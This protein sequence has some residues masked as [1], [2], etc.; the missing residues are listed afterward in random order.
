MKQLKLTA[1][2]A[3]IFTAASITSAVAAQQLTA[4]DEC[5]ID[6]YQEVFR[7]KAQT[8]EIV[9]VEIAPMQAKCEEKTGTKVRHPDLLKKGL[10]DF[11]AGGTRF[12]FK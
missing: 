7:T 1:L 9:E 8:A 2:C 4:A 3:T 12:L 11:S 6:A 5:M 10:S